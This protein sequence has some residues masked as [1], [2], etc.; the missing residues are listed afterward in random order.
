MTAARSACD[1]GDRP[2]KAWYAVELVHDRQ[3]VEVLLLL[4]RDVE[5]EEHDVVE[6]GGCASRVEEGLEKGLEKFH[7]HMDVS[8]SD[9]Q[10]TKLATDFETG[11]GQGKRFLLHGLSPLAILG[12]VKVGIV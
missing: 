6:S 10:G 4:L 5:E 8:A 3:D 11:V 7:G 9:Q 12:L 1:V 2:L